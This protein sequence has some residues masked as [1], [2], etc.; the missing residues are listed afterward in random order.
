MSSMRDERLGT[1]TIR[2]LASWLRIIPM[3]NLGEKIDL[4][5]S[6]NCFLYGRKKKCKKKIKKEKNRE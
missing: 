1:T 5:F 3:G 4:M 6:L 2:V